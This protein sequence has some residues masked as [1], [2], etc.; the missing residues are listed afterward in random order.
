MQMSRLELAA[1]TWGMK[2]SYKILVVYVK[3]KTSFNDL[4]INGK[5]IWKYILRKIM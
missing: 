3:W 2:N 5:L 4:G 1:R